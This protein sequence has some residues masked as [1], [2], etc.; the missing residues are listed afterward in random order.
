MNGT[1]TAM[2]AILSLGAV[3]ALLGL[4]VWA[5]K[6]GSLKLSRLAPR[7]AITIETA[8]SLGERRSLAIVK[9]EGRRLLVGM[10]PAAISLLADLA[11]A[12]PLTPDSGAQPG[13]A[14]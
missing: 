14:A 12:A 5:L 3:L 7:G 8:T 4:F 6:R 9:V 11:P 1:L 13:A 10:T 2:R